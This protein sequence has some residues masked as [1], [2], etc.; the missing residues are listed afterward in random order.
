MDLSRWFPMTE[1]HEQAETLDC[2]HGADLDDNA[3]DRSSSR[4]HGSSVTSRGSGVA[5]GPR[6]SDPVQRITGVGPR[7]AYE[8]AAAGIETV[9]DL[10]LQLPRRYEDRT[11]RVEVAELAE[12]VGRVAVTVVVQ[13]RSSRSVSQGWSG[14]RRRGRTEARVGDSSG[15]IEV[16]WFN[17]PYLSRQLVAGCW[18]TLFG[19][20]SLHEGKPQMTN[21]ALERLARPSLEVGRVVPVHRSL[22]SIGATTVRRLVATA[23]KDLAEEAETLPSAVVR[24]ERLLSRVEAFRRLHEPVC[25]KE[26]R[27]QPREQRAPK[28]RKEPREPREPRLRPMTCATPV[29]NLAAWRSEAH[30]RLVFDELIE[31]HALLALQQRAR[32]GARGRQR[33][34]MDRDLATVCEPLPFDLTAGQR[35]AINEILV[36][37]RSPRPMHRL[38][39][40]DVGCGKTAVAGCVM[41]MVAAA[42]GGEQAAMLVPT[43]ILAEQQAAVLGS[44]AE[45][46]G[47]RVA[48]L[49]SRLT[50]DERNRTLA[51]L[52]S[53]A[54]D[55]V[56]GTHALLQARVE[57][58]DLGLVVVD[59]QHRFGVR[60]RLALLGPKRGESEAGARADLLV[61]TATPIPRSLAL[62]LY[63]D[64]DVSA[65][66]DRPRGRRPVSTERCAPAEWPRVVHKLRD[67]VARG[68]QAYVVTPRIR[69]LD[70]PAEMSENAESSTSLSAEAAADRLRRALPDLR[71]G[72]VHGAQ[73]AETRAESMRAFASGVLDVLV[74][75]TVIE[76][77]LDVSSATLMVVDHAQRFGLAQLHQLRGRVG[78]G[79]Q[80]SECVLVAHEPLTPV[81]ESRLQMLCSSEDGFAIAEE[82]LRLRGPGE[83]LG[84][85]QAGWRGFSV[86]DP[87][88][89]A[90]WLERSHDIAREIVERARVA[91]GSASGSTTADS[92]HGADGDE[93]CAFCDRL[94][95]GWHEQGEPCA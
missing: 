86:A 67:V 75:T 34:L 65:I 43:T 46:L 48:C 80:P 83:L 92:E 11:R 9:D 74:A 4:R 22:G 61:M 52:A 25:G 88:Q 72:L 15:E 42:R 81:A 8:L 76:V 87:T 56:V 51:D 13:V 1:L 30:R 2:S 32:S 3:S 90:E 94:L 20:V 82:D 33:R 84:T 85:A 17:Q 70:K 64:L 7:R 37:L 78:R 54:I 66:P 27:E 47:L 36:D 6:L 35:Q 18:I 93:A 12:L 91:R 24:G 5:H 50:A 57:F 60:Q 41:L 69:D 79:S 62:T 58:H 59:E 28:E 77:G 38:L 23:L 26:P 31:F 71:I 53:G 21:P 63:G 45:S 10:L 19:R 55:V 89:H 39:H 49:T 44:W 14:R 29:E 16:I 73:D 68:E 40:G 95:P